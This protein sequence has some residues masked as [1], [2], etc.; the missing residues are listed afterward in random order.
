M[1]Q[2]GFRQTHIPCYYFNCLLRLIIFSTIKI[3]PGL[4]ESTSNA[5]RE[6]S[7]REA[8]HDLV[9]QVN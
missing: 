9:I 7:E 3:P 5:K 1:K 8:V 4:H 2:D 6:A